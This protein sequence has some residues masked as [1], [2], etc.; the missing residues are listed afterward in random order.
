S[1]AL[2][3]R[4]DV[5]FGDDDDLTRRKVARFPCLPKSGSLPSS[6]LKDSLASKRSIF[7]APSPWPSLVR[8][9]RAAIAQ[10]P[11]FG[12]NDSPPKHLPEQAAA[13]S[14][15]PIVGMINQGRKSIFRQS[16]RIISLFG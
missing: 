7:Q 2:D 5:H 10:D 1:R 14:E 11:Y 8:L 9:A 16:H 15:A 13:F 3:E 4:L 12:T 6:T